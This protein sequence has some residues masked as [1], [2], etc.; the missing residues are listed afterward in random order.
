MLEIKQEILAEQIGLSQQSISRIE[1]R[2]KLNDKLLS[3]IALEMQVP[4][5]ALKN[6]RKENFINFIKDFCH[7]KSEESPVSPSKYIFEPFEKVVE[8][9]EQ[10]L[11]ETSKTASFGVG[12]SPVGEGLTVMGNRKN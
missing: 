11:K 7:K 10:M 5:E 3:K 12:R 1:N 6:F 8:L 9:Y 4:V 2:E